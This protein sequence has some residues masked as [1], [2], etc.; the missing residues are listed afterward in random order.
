MQRYTCE[1]LLAD[2]WVSGEHFRIVKD[3]AESAAHAAEEHVAAGSLGGAARR[4]RLHNAK[5]KFR[6][7]I[8]AIMAANLLSHLLAGLE[9]EKVLVSIGQVYDEA[10]LRE[11][12]EVFG[13][14]AAAESHDD[15]REGFFDVAA[16]KA[17]TKVLS[18]EGFCAVL[19]RYEFSNFNSIL[20][21]FYFDLIRHICDQNL[22]G[23][24]GLDRSGRRAVQAIPGAGPI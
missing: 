1:Q 3:R 6:R 19:M 23:G 22:P 13:Q 11:L 24:R 10:R 14:R 20:I 7:G 15:E 4:M 2:P 16:L 9:K 17:S 8:R 21:R 18:K 5:R 12:Y